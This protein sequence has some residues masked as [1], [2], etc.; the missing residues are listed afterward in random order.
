MSPITFS[1]TLLVLAVA[2]TTAGAIRADATQADF[3]SYNAAVNVY[4]A[5]VERYEQAVA[6]FN[7]EVASY[8][9]GVA[10]Y[11]SLPADQRTQFQYDRLERWYNEL[12]SRSVA[13]D[14][15]LNYLQQRGA[16]LD[17]WYARLGG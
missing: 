16:E 7:N 3:D 10:Y 1:R 5:R 6:A 13:L 17:A 8:D 2:L 9:H 15:E 4:N 14:I 12:Q 11:N